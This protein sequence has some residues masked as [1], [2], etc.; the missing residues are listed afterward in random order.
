MRA[1]GL[2]I[3]GLLLVGCGQS[4]TGLRVGAYHACERAVGTTLRAPSTAD[5]SG[6]TGSDISNTGDN[7]VVR[8]YV[9]S[10]NGFGATIRTDFDCTVRHTSDDNWDLVDLNV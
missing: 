6:A 8:G 7:Y 9:D 1:L 2:V 4:A 10:E 5:Y 3:A